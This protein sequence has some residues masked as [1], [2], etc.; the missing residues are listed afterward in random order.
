MSDLIERDI[1]GE[2]EREIV[3]ISSIGTNPATGD[4]IFVESVYKIKN[5]VKMFSREGGVTQRIVDADGKVHL[6]PGIG[7]RGTI[8]RWTPRDVTNPVAF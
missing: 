5:P 4:Q 6:V 8:H 3:M 1:S 2:A 7:Y